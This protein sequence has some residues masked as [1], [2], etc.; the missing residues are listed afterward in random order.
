M[1]LNYKPLIKIILLLCCIIET[2]C[3][4]ETAKTVE[5]SS[6]YLKVEFSCTYPVWSVQSVMNVD[7][8]PDGNIQIGTGTLQYSGEVE[9][10]ES[11]Y[12]RS[13]MWQL[14]PVGVVENDVNETYVVINPEISVDYDI[15]RLYINGALF[16]EAPFSG[17]ID[18]SPVTFSYNEATTNSGGSIEGVSDAGGSIIWTLRLIPS[19]TVCEWMADNPFVGTWEYND[20]QITSTLVFSN[21]M[22]AIT[23]V[24][25]DD[26]HTEITDTNNYTYS[27]TATTLTL[28]KTGEADYITDYYINGISLTLSLNW[29]VPWTYTKVN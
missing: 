11:K 14:F 29:R 4:K 20:N 18:D 27:Y 6:G 3:T 24:V 15:T 23:T 26:G 19:T 13:G 17:A 25:T 8:N 10:D 2:A 9:T 7:V 28:K 22:K 16:L 12:T 5:A 21:D 1:D